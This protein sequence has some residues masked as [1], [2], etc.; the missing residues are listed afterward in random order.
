MSACQYRCAQWHEKLQK[1]GL[2]F[3]A[4][5]FPATTIHSSIYASTYTSSIC[6]ATRSPTGRNSLCLMK[7]FRTFGRRGRI[8]H[9]RLECINVERWNECVSPFVEA[10]AASRP[11]RQGIQFECGCAPIYFASSARCS[12][13]RRSVATAN[14]AASARSCRFTSRIKSTRTTAARTAP[15]R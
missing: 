4:L 13:M 8:H 7:D 5:A 3:F 10:A 1:H 15:P 14:R 11:P 9:L 2:S 6:F 12:S